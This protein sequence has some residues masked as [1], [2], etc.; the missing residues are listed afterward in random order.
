MAAKLTPPQ[1]ERLYHCYFVLHWRIYKCAK[2]VLCDRGTAAEYIHDERLRRDLLKAPSQRDNVRLLPLLGW[3]ARVA[4]GLKALLTIPR[5]IIALLAKAPADRLAK[6]LA[7]D[8][9]H[10]EHCA[11]PQLTAKQVA[12]LD[13][14]MAFSEHADEIYNDA[15]AGRCVDC[16]KMTGEIPGMGSP[17]CKKCAVD[18][19]KRRK[20]RKDVPESRPFP[21]KERS[22]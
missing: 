19:Y 3:L 12:F 8:D 4:D 2:D 16:E 13:A 1:I 22:R 9:H 5:E 17:L 20:A 14:Q 6:L 7:R 15:R 11:A 10:C 21:R 18:A